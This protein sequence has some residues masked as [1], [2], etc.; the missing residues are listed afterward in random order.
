MTELAFKSPQAG[1]V[2]PL[3]PP[4]KKTIIRRHRMGA[5]GLYMHAF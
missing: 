4:D 1:R 5:F 3:A 2:L